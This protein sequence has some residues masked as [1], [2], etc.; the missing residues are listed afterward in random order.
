MSRTLM[1]VMHVDW[2][3]LSH[4]LPIALEAQRQGYQ[5]HIATGLTD[6]Q[7]ELQRYGLVVHPL[8]VHL[9]LNSKE[10][11]PFAAM[12]THS[13]AHSDNVLP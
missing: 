3:F 2:A 13:A 1:F 4:R 9:F 11:H 8:V 5:V 6:K 10:M 12:A 7:V